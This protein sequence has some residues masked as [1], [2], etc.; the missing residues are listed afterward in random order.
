[1]SILFVEYP[2]CTTCR[3]AKKWLQEKGIDF[4]DRDIKEDNPSKEELKKWLEMS[5]LPI[6]KFFN[7]S[8]M[9]YREKGMKDKINTLSEEEL[10]DILSEDGMMVKRPIVVKD[11]RVL[12]GFKEE[13]FEEAL[14][15]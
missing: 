3:K 11:D 1:M 4:I 7:T 12:V 15:K 10:L 5:D 13:T 2:K 14:L 6:K 8:G 9:L